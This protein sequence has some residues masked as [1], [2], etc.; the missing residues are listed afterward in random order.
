VIANKGAGFSGIGTR[1]RKDQIAIDLVRIVKDG[2]E[3]SGEYRG[4]C[5]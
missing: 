4:I 5:W 1:L 3:T 2:S